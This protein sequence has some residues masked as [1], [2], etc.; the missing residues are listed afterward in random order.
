MRSASTR[1]DAR[2]EP[3]LDVVG[4]GAL[5]LDYI[6]SV[7]QHP[8]SLAAFTKALPSFA[9]PIAWNTE[10]LV[11]EFSSLPSPAE[12]TTAGIT[13]S[14]GG[15]SF[16]TI[17]ALASLGLELRLGYVGVVGKMPDGAPSFDDHLISAGIDRSYVRHDPSRSVGVCLSVI[18]HGE[19]TMSTHPGANVGMAEY[20][21][22]EF[23]AVVA[24][25]MTA[26]IIHVTSLLDPE[27][28]IALLKVL[29]E[30]KKRAPHVLITL[31]PG[32]DWCSRSDDYLA[33]LGTLSDYVLVNLP[34]LF[35]ACGEFEPTDEA[36]AARH[37]LRVL[38]RNSGVLVV[39]VPGIV[40][41]HRVVQ[42]SVAADSYRYAVLH[43]REVID[44]T[45]GDDVFTAGFIAGLLADPDRLGPGVL[46]GMKLA[47]THLQYMGFGGHGKF[48]A[49]THN[50][51]T[52][53][54]VRPRP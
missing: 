27:S 40:S 37:L 39:R 31:D 11:E 14:L 52:P 22:D 19:P 45:G 28:P 21:T 49:I 13:V 5:N 25:L 18:E 48:P 35:A 50:F 17:N 43:E 15:S 33:A 54:V 16:N 8:G 12:M 38:M 7:P 26:R 34:E 53:A 6:A 47:R 29:T 42:G 30:V 36:H 51:L 1:S 23:E 4:I 9:E 24:Y 44:A 2:P 3:T 41:C 46:L 32:F 20:L 10:R